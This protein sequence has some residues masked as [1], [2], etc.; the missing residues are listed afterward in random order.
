MVRR[1]Y[2]GID[3]PAPQI[4]LVRVHV[5]VQAYNYVLVWVVR[6][7]DRYWSAV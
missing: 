1:E 3:W 7:C 4:V 6:F 2:I 5:V